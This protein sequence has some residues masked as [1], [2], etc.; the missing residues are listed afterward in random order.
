MVIGILYDMHSY[1][2]SLHK[3]ERLKNISHLCPTYRGM[4]NVKWPL[5]FPQLCNHLAAR[6]HQLECYAR[7]SCPSPSELLLS[8]F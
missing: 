2:V 1:I 7:E 5:V 4:T 8:R 6:L 3:K